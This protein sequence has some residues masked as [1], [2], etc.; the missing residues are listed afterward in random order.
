MSYSRKEL[1][2][3]GRLAFDLKIIAPCLTATFSK[4]CSSY[5]KI[6]LYF[7]RET[8]C[9]FPNEGVVTHNRSISNEGD[10]LTNKGGR[11]DL[12][13]TYTGARGLVAI[14]AFASAYSLLIAAT[15]TEARLYLW[16]RADLASPLD[17]PRTLAR[18]ASKPS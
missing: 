15:L 17:C 11:G 12:T 18:P 2:L 7:P 9:I 3:L 13:I 1:H 6:I 14:F 10:T 4:L 16:V 5:L 8:F